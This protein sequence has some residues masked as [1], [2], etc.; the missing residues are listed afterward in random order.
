MR[1][2]LFVL[3]GR[4]KA[5]ARWP[6]AGIV[7]TVA[8]IVATVLAFVLYAGPALPWVMVVLAILVA[9]ATSR[10]L[11]VLRRAQDLVVAEHSHVDLLNSQI[12]E[13]QNAVDA[14][15]DGLDVALFICNPR[16]L[17]QFANGRAAEMFRATDPIGRSLLAVTLSPN[18]EALVLDA[19]TTGEPQHA[20]MNFKFPEDRVGVAKTWP[21]PDG[22]RVFLSIYETTELRRLERIRQDFV[23]NVSHELRTPMAIIRAMAETMI[24]TPEDYATKGEENLNRMIAEVDRLSLIS[25]DL[26]ILSAAESSIVRKHACNVARVLRSVV[27]G[28]DSRARDKGLELSYSGP[29]SVLIEANETQLTQVAMNLVENAINYTPAGKVG[30]Q[31]SVGGNEVTIQVRDSGIGIASDQVSRIF[32]RFYRVDKARSRS[33]GGTGLGLSIVKHIVEAH[34][35]SVE[36]NSSLN[37]GSTFT[38]VLPI[39]DISEPT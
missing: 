1:L 34:G 6:W 15:A 8:L 30:V 27:Q 36:V 26:L 29:E 23:A 37:N 19:S 11:A 10:D 13:Q 28:L 32:E 20:E 9:L 2:R 22:R 16:A 25:N 5:L 31:L 18:L 21:H 33:T 12:A 35:G 39:G 17:I 7:G 24:D 4:L 3:K 14:L 38:I